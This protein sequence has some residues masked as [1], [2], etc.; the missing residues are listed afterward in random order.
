MD[1][2][3]TYIRK[4]LKGWAARQQ[5]PI[6]GRE[7]LLAAASEKTFSRHGRRL[8]MRQQL[9]HVLITVVS[10]IA[11]LHHS[12]SPLP[13]TMFAEKIPFPSGKAILRKSSDA[14]HGLLNLGLLCSANV[15]SAGIHL[16]L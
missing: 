8:V 3:D 6:H 13:A 4:Q 12:R 14:T 2:F 9:R 11:R 5:Y 10:S 7:R 15:N 16:R 1:L